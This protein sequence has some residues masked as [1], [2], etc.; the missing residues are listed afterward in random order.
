M[1][2]RIYT[3]DELVRRFVKV[4]EA[5]GCW[6]WTGRS[7]EGQGLLTYRRREWRA[8]RLLYT[9][10]HGEIP[11]GKLL[12]RTCQTPGCVHPDHMRIGTAEDVCSLRD[13]RGT[14]AKG[15]TMGKLRTEQVMSIR[16]EYA[17]NTS[18]SV[19][20]RKYGVDPATIRSI[21]YRATW[22]HLE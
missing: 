18:I 6:L 12:L 11:E 5:T 10:W 1:G 14:T 20:A 17:A 13:Q 16:Q 4:V 15:E 21:V 2:R 22:R 8:H 9:F 19:L 7:R 3:P